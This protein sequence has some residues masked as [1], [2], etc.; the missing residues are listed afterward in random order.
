M[1]N[2]SNALLALTPISKN[3][4]KKITNTLKIEKEDFKVYE[5]VTLRRLS[6]FKLLLELRKIRSQNLYL[7]FEESNARNLIPIL[8]CIAAFTSAQSIWILDNEL[9]ITKYSRFRIMS[10]LYALVSGTIIAHKNLMLCYWEMKKLLKNDRM[11]FKQSENKNILYLKTNL[12]YGVQVGGSIGHISGVINAFI[13][14]KFN[15]LFTSMENPIMLDPN[16]KINAIPSIKNYGLPQE[17]NLYTFQRHIVNYFKNG[18]FETQNFKFIY[19]RMAISNYANVIISRYLKIPLILEYNGSEVW[20]SEKWGNGLRYK[21]AAQMAENVCLKHAQLI[22]VV[23]EVLKDELVSRGIEKNRIL[24]YPNCIDPQHFNPFIYTEDSIL[25]L[26]KEYKLN[27][28]NK[29]LT[30]VGT[31]GQWH[32]AEKFAEAIKSL[33]INEVEWLISKKVHF[34]LIG[35]G[36]KMVEVKGFLDNDTCAPFVTLTGL[37]PQKEAP[38]HL[39]MS[40]ILVSPHV[41][42]SDGSKFFGS[43]TK[44]FEYMAMGK[45]IIASNLDQIGEVLKN[46]LYVDSLPTDMQNNGELALLV[47]PGNVDDLVKA[48]KFLIENE[49]WS[50]ELGKNVA[51]EAQKKY[52]WEIHVNE[53]LKSFNNTFKD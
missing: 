39:A 17:V 43:P 24:F 2:Q 14:N 49:N 7:V 46:S 5:L 31:F 19:S 30:F 26:R 27:Q 35:N 40:D 1:Q 8:C 53:I 3:F 38:L 36:L 42:N 44:L 47:K 9:V 13:K 32:G 48:I 21:K 41:P 45:G 16:V 29:I 50:R 12:W 25:K 10:S 33:C 11:K 52:T 4:E 6:I 51:I 22:V 15:V 20:V 23:S 37:I 34:M 18:N 28:E